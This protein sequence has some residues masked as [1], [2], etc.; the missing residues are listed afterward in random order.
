MDNNKHT[1]SLE[2]RKITL[3]AVADGK[4]SMWRVKPVGAG[5]LPDSL[6]GMFT[7]K[8]KAEQAIQVYYET[9]VKKPSELK[10]STDIMGEIVVE[11]EEEKNSLFKFLK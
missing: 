3:E 1:E 8:P 4:Y 6:R 7:D 2:R 11:T 5:R 9:G 10:V